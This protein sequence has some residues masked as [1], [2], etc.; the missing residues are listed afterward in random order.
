MSLALVQFADQEQLSVVGRELDSFFAERVRR[1]AEHGE[2][3]RRL[4]EAARVASA[5]GKRI[6]PALVVA[7]HRALG[8]TASTAAV[9]VATAFELLHTAFLLHDDVIDRDV[10]RRGRPNLVGE[11]VLEA[12]DLGVDE[13]DAELWGQSSAILAGDL[14][15]H[16]AQGLVA[17]I[18]G[19]DDRRTA[20]LELLD[21]CVFVT[22]AGELADVAFSTRVERPSFA[23]AV[24]MSRNKTASY[25]FEGPLMAGAILA[26][27]PQPV[28]DGL[29]SFGRMIGTAFQLRDDLLGV[30][31]EE[32]VTGKSVMSDL[33]SRKVTPLMAFAASTDAGP[34]LDRLLGVDPLDELAASAIR[35]L[36]IECGARSHIERIIRRHV[37][38]AIEVIDT[39][40]FPVTLRVQ[41]RRIALEATERLA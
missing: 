33:R 27:A 24:A 2:G 35:T 31:G 8:G 9:R 26:D 18:P 22:A 25:T 28:V 34:E 13:A 3:Y 6:R 17:A 15:I 20:L 23:T 14:L 36:L 11:R 29:G 39:A 4:W 21:H 16:A 1:A 10:V 40:P 5:G 12:A 37:Q 32:A 38:D 41:L 19:P 7:S 30:F